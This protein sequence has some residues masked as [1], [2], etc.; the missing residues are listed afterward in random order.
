MID[1]GETDWKLLAIDVN[2][3]LAEKLNDVADIEKEM[4]GFIAATVEWFKIYKMPDGKPANE[5]AFNAE[6]KDKAF[7]LNI[8]K[9]LNQQWQKMMAAGS[10]SWLFILFE[11]HVM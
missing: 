8:V 3:P 11:C 9:E 2:D 6:P 7:A 5:F 1:E 10:V 4:P